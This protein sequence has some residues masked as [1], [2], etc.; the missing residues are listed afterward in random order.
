MK[1]FVAISLVV[2][3][4]IAVGVFV[5]CSSSE[6]EEAATAAKGTVDKAKEVAATAEEQAVDLASFDNHEEGVCPVCKMNVE[7]A[8]VEVAKVEEK[9]YA[10]C[11]ERCVAMLQE[12]PDKYLTAEATGHEG[13]N[14]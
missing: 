14:H 5:G 3:L 2:A 7:A 10:C 8:Y 4:V 13:H 12:A 6:T 11:S 1:S 9:K